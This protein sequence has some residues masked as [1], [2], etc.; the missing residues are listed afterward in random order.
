M[1]K[2]WINR[3][4]EQIGGKVYG[5]HRTSAER[6]LRNKGLWPEPAF[7]APEPDAATV[8]RWMFREGCIRIVELPEQVMVDT[9]G[10]QTSRA[11]REAI[12]D[13]MFRGGAE[14]QLSVDNKVFESTRDGGEN[15]RQ[16]HK[17]H[18]SRARRILDFWKIVTMSK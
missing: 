14:R 9:G 16:Y 1:I 7:G 6:Y 12:E 8:Y 5:H 10:V 18:A 13:A 3:G 11:Q 15:A 17:V 4:G 2:Y